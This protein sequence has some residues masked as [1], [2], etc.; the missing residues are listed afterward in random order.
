MSCPSDDSSM[1][2]MEGGESRHSDAPST[3]PPMDTDCEVGDESDEP[4]G[5]EEGVDGQMS[6]GD[7]AETNTHTNQHRCP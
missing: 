4:I 3:K 7:E 2:S 6:A 5:S 1:T